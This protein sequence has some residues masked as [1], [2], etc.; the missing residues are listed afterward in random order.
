MGCTKK[1]LS[2]S[3]HRTNYSN[4]KEYTSASLPYM[5]TV[6]VLAINDTFL[7]LLSCVRKSKQTTKL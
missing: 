5:V 1:D 2:V 7:M 4:V 6:I 3:F